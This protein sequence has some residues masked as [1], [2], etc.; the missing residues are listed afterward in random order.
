MKSVLILLFTIGILPSFCQDTLANPPRPG[1][2]KWTTMRTV[3]R[4]GLGI[5]RTAYLE[6]GLARHRF[7][8][9]DLGFAS[10]AYYGAFEWTPIKNIYG[11]KA[12]YE[13][14][15]RT[16]ALGIEAKCQTNL[17]GTDIVLTPRVG[18]GAM[19]IVNIFYGFN[20]SFMKRPFSSVGPHQ[21]SIVFN[22]NKLAFKKGRTPEKDG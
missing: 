17:S 7:I 22:Y 6:L 2:K 14:N 10:A 3:P 12:G 4:I 20:I 18:F 11:L 8:F 15:A 21:F 1:Y 5:Q 19:G 9:N 13:I 16:A